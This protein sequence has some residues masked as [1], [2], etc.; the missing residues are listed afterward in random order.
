MAVF[1]NRLRIAPYINPNNRNI[2]GTLP[3]PG[4]VPNSYPYEGS[5]PPTPPLPPESFMA[6]GPVPLVQTVG[7]GTL[8]TYVGEIMVD[9]DG[10]YYIYSRFGSLHPTKTATIVAKDVAGNT[11]ATL[12]YAGDVAS[13]GPSTGITLPAFQY[14]MFYAYSEDYQCSWFITSINLRR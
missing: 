2:R 12:S 6:V 8:E 9:V 4:D 10:V 7:S 1:K 11:L 13:V 5:V 14:V 3:S